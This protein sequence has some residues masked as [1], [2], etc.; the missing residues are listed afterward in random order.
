MPQPHLHHIRPVILAHLRG[1]TQT[2]EAAV[3]WFTDDAIF[4]LLLQRLRVGIAVSLVLHDDAINRNK[5]F[6]WPEF[7]HLGG[8]AYWF[9]DPTG[10]TMHHKFCLIDGQTLMLGSYNWTYQAANRNRENLLVLTS[11]DGIDLVPFRQE[12]AELIRLSRPV[13]EPVFPPVSP[14]TAPIPTS[15]EL[16]RNPLP[17]WLRARIRTLTIELAVLEEEKRDA[18]SLITQYQYLIRLHL[19]D[20]ILAIAQ[21]KAQ[22]AEQH[23]AN[24]GRR[25]DAEHAQAFRAAYEQTTH[26]VRE[27]RAN[28]Q[29]VLT[30]DAQ[31]E[32]RRLFRKAAA[33]A[34]PDRFASDPDCSAAAHAF[35]T[36]LNDAYARKALKTLRQLVADLDDGLIFDTASEQ[37][38]EV[39]VL[40]KRLSRLMTRR[41]E[42]TAE[43][44]ALHQQEGYQWMTADTDRDERLRQMHDDLVKTKEELRTI[45]L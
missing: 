36:R 16:T 22:R 20:L 2:I 14:P 33:K 38:N 25:S 19:G 24:S 32:L 13:V 7:A 42:L 40:E 5:P 31:A 4:D 39:D 18:E 10:G 35:M 34:H 45:V 6:D 23:A 17:D 28:P 29:P 26:Q 8:K 12:L 15:G 27:A 3:A 44:A 1:A 21:L 9:N 30:D 37:T 43:L 11:D 41:A